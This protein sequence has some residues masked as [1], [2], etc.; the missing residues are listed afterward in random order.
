L[1]VAVT[2]ATNPSSTGITVKTDLSSIGGLATQTFFDDG[3]NGDVTA[4]DS[5]FSYALAVPAN[6]T[7]GSYNFT[8]TIT[9]AQARNA[10][11]QI[12][13][14]LTAAHD[15]AEHLVMGIRAGRRQM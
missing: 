12:T 5:V 7:V 2:P 4:G 14:N 13:L 6:A 15:A 10:S 11:A 1:T 8:S 3:T 9:D